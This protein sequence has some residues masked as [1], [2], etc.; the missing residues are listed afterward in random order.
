MNE[1]YC[2]KS[3]ILVQYDTF[4][5][6]SASYDLPLLAF[7]FCKHM[8]LLYSAGFSQAIGCHGQLHVL[9]KNELPLLLE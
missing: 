9:T 6:I 3:G 8:L 4:T 7:L 1:G 5:F 2:E